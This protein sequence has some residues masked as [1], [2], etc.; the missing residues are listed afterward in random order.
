MRQFQL[1]VTALIRRIFVLIH[2]FCECNCLRPVWSSSIA[3]KTWMNSCKCTQW[4][5]MN[6]YPSIV[7]TRLDLHTTGR[8]LHDSSDI[9]PPQLRTTMPCHQ[10][11]PRLHSLQTLTNGIPN[12]AHSVQYIRPCHST[13]RPI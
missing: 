2:K 6:L 7:S 12:L 11:K 3:E 9:P 10:Y 4:D 5:L 8:R 1:L 13:T